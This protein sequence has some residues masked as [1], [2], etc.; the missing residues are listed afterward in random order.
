MIKTYINGI[1]SGITE[2]TGGLNDANSDSIAQNTT[3][4]SEPALLKIASDAGT[5]DLYNVRVF[6][7]VLSDR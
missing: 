7:K 2:Y 1:I 3:A 4:G 6:N 5:V